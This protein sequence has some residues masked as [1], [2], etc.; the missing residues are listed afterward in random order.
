QTGRATQFD[1]GAGRHAGEPVF[2]PKEGI[3]G[4]DDGYLM[5]LVYDEGKH[6]SEL[7]ILDA[8]DM[9]R[10]AIAQVHIPSRVPYGFHGNWIP[11][12]VVGP[13]T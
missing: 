6:T 5:S 2:I 12:A 13:T 1:I 4:E 11:D 3:A 8:Q 9:A 7:L 10:P